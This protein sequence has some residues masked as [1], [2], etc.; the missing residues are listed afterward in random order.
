M[1]ITVTLFLQVHETVQTSSRYWATFVLSMVSVFIY[2]T[3]ILYCIYMPKI[4]G[5][6]LRYVNDSVGLQ[7]VQNDT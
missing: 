3:I 7:Q 6:M 5:S 4:Y 2:K 1:L